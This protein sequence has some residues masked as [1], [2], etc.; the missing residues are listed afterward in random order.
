MELKYRKNL[1]QFYIEIK[2]KSGLNI[3]N[4]LEKLTKDRFRH[5]NFQHIEEFIY[6]YYVGYLKASRQDALNKLN[7]LKNDY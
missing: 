5:W 4:D 6:R 1:I 3:Q 2:I 7:E